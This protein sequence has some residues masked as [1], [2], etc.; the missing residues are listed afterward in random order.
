MLRPDGGDL[1]LT[2]KGGVEEQTVRAT[3]FEVNLK[4]LE[5]AEKAREGV[6]WE[7]SFPDTKDDHAQRRE[8]DGDAGRNGEQ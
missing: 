7:V 2:D 1:D 6:V 8:Y 3:L 5:L 4:V